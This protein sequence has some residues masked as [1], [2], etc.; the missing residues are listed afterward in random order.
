MHRFMN[1]PVWSPRQQPLTSTRR[2]VMLAF[3]DRQRGPRWESRR[4]RGESVPRA[5]ADDAPAVEGPDY[6]G[7][8]CG[9]AESSGVGGMT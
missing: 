8:L 7:Q 9:R 4:L 1:N 6:G 5:K 3:E 2:E